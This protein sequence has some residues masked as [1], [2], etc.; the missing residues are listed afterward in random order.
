MV[1]IKQQAD[2]TIITPDAPVA[3]V[4]IYTT[5]RISKVKEDFL[6]RLHI[7]LEE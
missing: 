4:F 7:T 6:H 3:Q 2:K 5:K 1:E